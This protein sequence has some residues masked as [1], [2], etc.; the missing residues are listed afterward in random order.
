MKASNEYKRSK[1]ALSGKED[2][3]VGS[4]LLFMSCLIIMGTLNTRSVKVGWHDTYGSPLLRETMTE[5]GF[6]DH[7]A[8]LHFLGDTI[9]STEQAKDPFHKISWLLDAVSA[10]CEQNFTLGPFN[11]IDEMSVPYKGRYVCTRCS[12]SPSCVLHFC[13]STH[14]F[15]FLVS[16]IARR[17]NT[18]RI[19]PRNIISLHAAV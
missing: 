4:L 11:C 8:M 13:S 1:P 6:D 10:H 16:A 19:N 5:K 12:G 7:A 3:T 2:M 17:D 18:T 9:V 14:L 15:A